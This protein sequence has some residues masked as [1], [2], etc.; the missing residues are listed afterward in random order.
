MLE[1][2]VKRL[3]QENLENCWKQFSRT[4]YIAI[5]TINSAICMDSGTPEPLLN[6]IISFNPSENNL[7][8]EIERLEHFYAKK[9]L[10][11]CWW[12]PDSPLSNLIEKQLRIKGFIHS[13]QVKGMALDIT[14][15]A[16][17]NVFPNNIH[18]VQAKTHQ[19]FIDWMHVL[20]LAFDMEIF[21][22]DWYRNMLE[23]V[24][25][26]TDTMH[27]YIAYQEGQPVSSLTLFLDKKV[28]SF[29]NVGTIPSRRGNGLTSAMTLYCLELAREQGYNWATLQANSHSVRLFNRLGFES[30]ISYRVY[31]K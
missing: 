31:F 5:E 28:A 19:E 16:V 26:N 30:L 9:Q 2:Q 25:K 24:Q 18:L 17:K 7:T 14:K 22:A 4:G 21:A 13:M 1:E 6:S 11:F 10:P 12:I 23:K 20:R 29:Y 15:L 3:I 8:L 27:C